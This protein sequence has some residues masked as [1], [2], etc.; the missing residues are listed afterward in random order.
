[1]K[2]QRARFTRMFQRPRC[3]GRLRQPA[4]I[5]VEVLVRHVTALVTE[6]APRP[7]LVHLRR[8]RMPQFFM[9]QFHPANARCGLLR[10][11]H[12]HF[13]LLT[14]H[15]QLAQA[16][17]YAVAIIT[18]AVPPNG[19]RTLALTGLRY[20][21][22]ELY[23]HR[24]IGRHRRRRE[25]HQHFSVLHRHLFHR[26]LGRRTQPTRRI[27]ALLRR[28]ELHH[29]RVRLPPLLLPH[30]HHH[31]TRLPLHWLRFPRVYHHHIH[32][33]RTGFFF[34]VFTTTTYHFQFSSRKIRFH[35]LGCRRQPR[36]FFFR[37]FTTTTLVCRRTGF[38]FRVFTTTTYHFQFS[39]RK[40]RF[41]VL[42]RRRQPRRCC[43]VASG[44]HHHR[45]RRIAQVTLPLLVHRRT[46]AQFTLPLLTRRARRRRRHYNGRLSHR[47]HRFT[48]ILHYHHRFIHRGLER[49]FH[50]IIVGLHVHRHRL[51][52]H[53]HHLSII[54]RVA[55][56]QNVQVDLV[57]TPNQTHRVP[58]AMRVHQPRLITRRT[59]VRPQTILHR[60]RNG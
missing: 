41:H 59:I 56:R 50:V 11:L 6:L 42:G 18:S 20:L 7:H 32:R 5:A 1:M 16:R 9:A 55:D 37:I 48:T 12:F 21:E 34:R 26:A 39:S 49:R 30:F 22:V 44:F 19:P 14:A 24:R 8:R 57:C 43:T 31:H 28:V 36:L 58:N 38:F 27:V 17:P 40:I 51:A 47:R 2:R 33:R 54:N 53:V 60:R 52:N 35:V 4:P 10:S 46:L 45:I 29:H 25:L 13:H 23:L 3:G 15:R